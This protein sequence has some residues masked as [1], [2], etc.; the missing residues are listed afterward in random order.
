MVVE[1]RPVSCDE[2]AVM[3]VVDVGPGSRGNHVMTF[4]AGV[5]GMSSTI[6]FLENLILTQFKA[7]LAYI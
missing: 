7:E 1:L 3:A 6:Y 5:H 2:V 4:F